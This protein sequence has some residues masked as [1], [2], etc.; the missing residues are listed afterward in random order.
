ML[1]KALV[2]KIRD[3]CDMHV[4]AWQIGIDVIFVSI[5]FAHFWCK[6][7]PEVKNS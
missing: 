4:L 6:M 1:T 2:F 3:A 5:I 7:G